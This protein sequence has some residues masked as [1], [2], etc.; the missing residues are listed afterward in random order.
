[1][2]FNKALFLWAEQLDTEEGK[3]EA[4]NATFSARFQ[5]VSFMHGPGCWDF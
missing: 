4:L 2:F 3:Y 1:M 5:P